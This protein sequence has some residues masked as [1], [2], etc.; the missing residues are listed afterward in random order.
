MLFLQG[1]RDELADWDSINE[2]LTKTAS[3]LAPPFARIEAADHS[4]HLLARSRS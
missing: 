3:T 2:S 1:T 4:F